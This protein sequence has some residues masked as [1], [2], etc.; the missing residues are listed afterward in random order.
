MSQDKRII[1]WKDADR[2][3]CAIAA[4]M[5][6][7]AMK[8]RLT[9]LQWERE[10]NQLFDNDAREIPLT[11]EDKNGKQYPPGIWTDEAEANFT[12]GATIWAREE[13]SPQCFYSLANIIRLR[14]KHARLM[15]YRNLFGTGNPARGSKQRSRNP[16]GRKGS[17]YGRQA[18]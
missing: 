14:L 15:L 10:Y 7:E 1:T 18:D 6:D 4:K 16:E 2:K 3:L 17:K 8:M 13:L 5:L 9:P 12:T 11:G